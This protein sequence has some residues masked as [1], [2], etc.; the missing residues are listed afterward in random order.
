MNFASYE[1]QENY[2]APD[3]QTDNSSF[4][5]GS[6]SPPARSM[7][8]FSDK[9]VVPS[10]TN[11]IDRLR[12]IEQTENSLAHYSATIITGRAGMG[13]TTLAT[14]FAAQSKANI[15]WYQVETADSDW[16]IFASYLAGSLKQTRTVAAADSIKFNA[17]EV[18]AQSEMLAARFAEAAEREPLLIVLDDLHSVFDAEWFAEFFNSFVSSLTPNVQL[19]LVART[20]PPL[21]VWR[22]RSKQI[23]GV[24]EEKLLAFTPEETVKFFDTYQ[25]PAKIAAVAHQIAYGKI[26]KLKEIAE[27]NSTLQN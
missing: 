25:L 1:E 19:L 3:Y 18:A 16:E 23:L 26:S 10:L 21:A 15:I 8:L 5:V 6:F 17:A 20:L 11:E 27:K 4:A 14:Q 7:K 13:K 24:V 2:A 9:F 22:L 12:L